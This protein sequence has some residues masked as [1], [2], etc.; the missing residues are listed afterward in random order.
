MALLA[1]AGRQGCARALVR[2]A[3]P[4][5]AQAVQG[6][7][8]DGGRR[9]VRARPQCRV[10]ARRETRGRGPGL[11]P[12][13]EVGLRVRLGLGQPRR[14]PLHRRARDGFWGAARHQ[15]RALGYD[16]GRSRAGFAEHSGR[17]RAQPDRRRGRA[18]PRHRARPRGLQE[19]PRPAKQ[20]PHHETVQ[21]G[22]QPPA[23][24]QRDDAERRQ[25]VREGP[26][27]QFG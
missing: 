19:Q 24:R 11:D 20:D 4:V 5:R 6:R 12:G 2:R 16:R 25:S 17:H 13:P 22:L 14:A 7:I 26:T 8:D 10:Q 15:Y 1:G 3:A 9:A 27:Y 21:P 23:H 18:Q